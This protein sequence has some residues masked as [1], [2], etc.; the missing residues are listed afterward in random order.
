V[1][2]IKPALTSQYTPI[3]LRNSHASADCKQHLG[4]T[5]V[6]AHMPQ[7]LIT[8]R[9]WLQRQ[10]QCLFRYTSLPCNTAIPQS[11]YKTLQNLAN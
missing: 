9:W 8:I 3:S 1:G 10:I 4:P 2:F 7:K 6:M 5:M 11:V